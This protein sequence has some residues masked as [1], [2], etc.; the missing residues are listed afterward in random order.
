MS[1]LRNKTN[2]ESI[3]LRRRRRYAVDGAPLK[4]S[5]LDTTGKMRVS[6]TRALNISEFGMALQ[7]PEPV[8]PLLVRFQSDRFDVNGAG[9]VRY[10]YRMKGKY[11]VGLEFTGD[12]RWHA[13]EEDIAEP[14]PVC[15][16]S[17]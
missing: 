7:L 3:E 5:W 10:C 15:D 14:I 16:P 9:A 1:T 2:D 11:V 17:A 4:V 12:L 8:M 6:R 13:P